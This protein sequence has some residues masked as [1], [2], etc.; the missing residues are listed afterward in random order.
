MHRGAQRTRLSYIHT[1]G[2]LIAFFGGIFALHAQ[3]RPSIT[4]S[5]NATSIWEAG[6]A[7]GFTKGTFDLNLS[8][9]AGIGVEILGG[10]HAHDWGMGSLEFGW[11]VSQTRG[12][13]HWYRGNWEV[14]MEAFGGAQYHPS[15]AYFVG[16]GPHLRY[17][18]APGH[19]LVPFA[20][21]GAGLT[22]T[23]IRDGDLSTPFEFNLSAGIG[24]HAFVSDNVALTF[25]CRLI[26]MSN[27]GIDV[28]NQGVNTVNLIFGATWFF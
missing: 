22:S 19:G 21:F 18:F 17:D 26:H 16:G 20:E 3:D 6:V 9:G 13:E 25:Q 2:A 28:P 4:L 15:D 7:Q 12:Q 14:L 8:G 10:R 1:L 27:A 11:I 24:L 23:T 5:S